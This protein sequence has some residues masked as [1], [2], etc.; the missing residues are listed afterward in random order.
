MT[1]TFNT[2]YIGT[3]L[4]GLVLFSFQGTYEEIIYRGYLL[5]HFAKKWGIVIAILVSSC[6]IYFTSCNE[7]RYDSNA[8]C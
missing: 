8:S 7:S 6:F 3:I 5:P 2:E 1:Y 4:I